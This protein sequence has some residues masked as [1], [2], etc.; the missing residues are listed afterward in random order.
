M[1]S[2]SRYTRREQLTFLQSL[3]YRPQGGIGGIRCGEPAVRIF[4]LSR[5]LGLPRGTLLAFLGISLASVNRRVEAHLP[6]S[7]EESKRVE[8]IESM[9]GQV[10]AMVE[11]GVPDETAGFD[12]ARWLGHWLRH[13]LPALGGRLPASYLHTLD[14]QRLVRKMLAMIA[15]GS[16]A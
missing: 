7:V 1:G 4:E 10:Q 13:P 16:Y 5:L 3:P 15:S 11:E 9:V 14:G 2:S 6:L 8:G 12:A